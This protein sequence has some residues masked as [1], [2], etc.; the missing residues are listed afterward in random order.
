MKGT[1]AGD[2]GEHAGERGSGDCQSGGDN[3][4]DDDHVDQLAEHPAPHSLAHLN[5]HLAGAGLVPKGCQV[6]DAVHVHIRRNG[7]IDANGDDH[8][9]GGTEAH[10]GGGDE[11]EQVGDRLGTSARGEGRDGIGL[12][13]FTAAQV[14]ELGG[15]VAEAAGHLV[16][17]LLA[18]GDKA[19][20]GPVAQ[21]ANGD[22]QEQKHDEHGR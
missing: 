7:E 8:E 15:D 6:R 4:A 10:G 16:P 11:P 13:A 20:A 18:L 22:D 21:A 14:E 3:E 2:D 12:A 9:H 17:E 5:E 19:R 1:H